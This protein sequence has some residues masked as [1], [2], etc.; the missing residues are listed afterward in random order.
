MKK[1][2]FMLVFGFWV[3]NYIAKAQTIILISK[4]KNENI[5]NWLLQSNNSIVTKEFYFLSPDSQQFFLKQ[6][7][8]IVIGGGEDVNPNL[9]QAA[10]QINDCGKID[11]YRDSIE[12]VLIKHALKMNIPILGIC[13]G[14]QILNVAT[15]GSLIVDIPKAIKS[16]LKHAQPGIDSV[17]WV[18]VKPKS[19]LKTAMNLD[20]LMVNS[21]H[22]QAVKN[23]SPKFKITAKSSDG[24]I[25]AIE[26]KNNSHPFAAAIQWHPE[27]LFNEA[28]KQLSKSFVLKTK[29][30]L[31]Y[32]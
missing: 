10:D 11:N 2:L 20:S 19:W 16:D 6:C 5:K 22:H 25:E 30:K 18:Y 14:Q 31:R 4:D 27:R 29:N 12:Y 26:W 13:R 23:I 15:G 32:K 7:N 9:Y 17:H 24:I 21:S 3:C 8:G 1:Q 28:S